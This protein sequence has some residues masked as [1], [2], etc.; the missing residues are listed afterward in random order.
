MPQVLSEV[1]GA[2]QAELT[3]NRYFVVE[4]VHLDPGGAFDGFCDGETLEIWGCVGGDAQ[5]EWE[6][7]RVPLPTIRYALL[8]A[9]LGDY[10]ITSRG[11][12][13]CLRVYLPKG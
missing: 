11:P 13:T 4:E 8:P 1:G 5:I 12:S 10:R 3:R 7:G 9:A 6:G 2:R